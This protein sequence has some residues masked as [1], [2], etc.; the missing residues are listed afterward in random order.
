[1]NKRIVPRKGELPK[2]ILN[3]WH[4]ERNTDVINELVLPFDYAANVMGTI[5]L[6]LFP[7]SILFPSHII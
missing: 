2:N 4:Q 5:I 6:K 3:L 7:V 1:M